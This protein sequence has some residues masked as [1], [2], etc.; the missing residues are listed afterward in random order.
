MCFKEIE[1][2]GFGTNFYSTSYHYQEIDGCNGT[3][4]NDY[5]VTHI[6]TMGGAL[7]MLFSLAI[8]LLVFKVFVWK[9]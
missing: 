8:T 1:L 9:R 3:V 7:W 6:N 4:L 2:K 5:N